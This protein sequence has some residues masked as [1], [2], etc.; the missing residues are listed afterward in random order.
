[1]A[2]TVKASGKSD[3]K[4][5]PVLIFNPK[6]NRFESLLR[7]EPPMPKLLKRLHCHCAMPHTLSLSLT[8]LEIQG[9]KYWAKSLQDFKSKINLF[10]I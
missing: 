10:N 5:A 9:A 6:G 4:S 2:I 1:M 3:I 7:H 8:L